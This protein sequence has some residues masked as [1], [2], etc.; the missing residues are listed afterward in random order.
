MVSSR[1]RGMRHNTKGNYSVLERTPN[2]M[3]RQIIRELR[4]PWWAVPVAHPNDT[5][6]W[7][8]LC[9]FFESQPCVYV[10][11]MQIATQQ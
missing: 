7:G 4:S 6:Y 5:K 9:P 11:E 2:L 8:E 3:A 1:L 10:F